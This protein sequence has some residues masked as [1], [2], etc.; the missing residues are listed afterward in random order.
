MQGFI[1]S[2]NTALTNMLNTIE[3]EVSNTASTLSQMESP[4]ETSLRS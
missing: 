4:L 3:Q 1:E 2:S